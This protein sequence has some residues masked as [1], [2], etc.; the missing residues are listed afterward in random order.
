MKMALEWYDSGQENRDEFIGMIKSITAI[1]QGESACVG[2]R[3]ELAMERVLR[4]QAWC[5]EMEIE[6]N[7]T[8]ITLRIKE[9]EHQCCAEDLLLWRKSAELAIQENV[10]LRAAAAIGETK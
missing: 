1:A 3:E 9:E 10:E 4:D 2:L 7:T 5:D 6:L 8:R